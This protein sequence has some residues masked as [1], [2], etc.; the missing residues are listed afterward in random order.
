MS[1]SLVDIFEPPCDFTR[2]DELFPGKWRDDGSADGLYGHRPYPPSYIERLLTKIDRDA[3]RRAALER[4]IAFDEK[5]TETIPN[6]MMLETQQ[7]RRRHRPHGRVWTDDLPDGT[8]FFAEYCSTQRPE[9][10]SLLMKWR[11][12][13]LELRAALDP[14]FR[15][16][17][18]RGDWD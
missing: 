5:M 17:L 3:D 12:F 15:Y 18:E 7:A 9:F 14:D 11:T 13:S 6:N 10:W 1:A 8:M 2:Q 4:V 16:E